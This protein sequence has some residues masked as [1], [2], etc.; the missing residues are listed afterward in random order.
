M[1]TATGT[2]RALPSR[3]ASFLRTVSRTQTTATTASTINPDAA[4]VCDETDNDCDEA[5]DD[6]DDSLDASTGSEFYADSD[7]DG[8]GDA[9]SP[10]QACEQPSGTVVD[11]TDC[12]DGNG[13]INPG[14][15]EVCD[16]VDNDCDGD[17]DDDDTSLDTSTQTTWYA[18]T[19]SDGEGDPDASV[20]ACS[21]PSGYVDNSDDCD[22]T[23]ASDLDGD[24]IQDCAD[25]DRDGDGLRNDWDVEPDDDSVTR[26]PSGGLGTD[27]AYTV[28]SGTTDVQEDWTDL[29]S[30][31]SS[32]STSITVVDSSFLSSGDEILILVQQG[33]GAGTHE[34]VFVSSVSGNTLTLEPPLTN[35]YSG[36]AV[37]L[38]QRVPHYT[39]VDIAGTLT[40]DSWEDAANGVV[41]FRAQDA[42]AISGTVDADG[43]GFRGGTEVRGNNST[44]TPG[45]SYS[46]TAS[47]DGTNN[48]GGGGAYYVLAD[49][50]YCGAGGGYGDSGENGS[51]TYYS[52]WSRV[53]GRAAT[54]TET[55]P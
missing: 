41:V 53:V 47:A 7:S 46:G 40:T 27:G 22:D 21:Q 11:A 43:A 55:R 51:R 29:S 37:V 5:T 20:D 18:D 14:A 15:T 36:S 31:A 28:S 33:S 32:G 35:G 3:P 4:E 44:S 26:G 50:C 19:D 49:R 25:D 48:D 23:D 38:V 54:P 10:V 30:T 39:T 17:I 9:T 42:V 1:A 12:E 6:A 2:V 16:E 45:E 52:Y 24:G 34:F 8:Y 13:D